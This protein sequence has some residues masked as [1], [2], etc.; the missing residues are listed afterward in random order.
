VS[1]PLRHHL[2]VVLATAYLQHRLDCDGWH[3]ACCHDHQLVVQLTRGGTAKYCVA[4]DC[5][6]GV[7]KAVCH[8]SRAWALAIT[9]LHGEDNLAPQSVTEIKAGLCE[10]HA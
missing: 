1:L 2:D 3:V 5:S 10:L 4:Y 6:P 8:G 9:P 7:E